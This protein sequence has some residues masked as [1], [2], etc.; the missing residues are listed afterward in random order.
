MVT[1]M[2]D[3]I[4]L[5]QKKNNCHLEPNLRLLETDFLRIRYQHSKIPINPSNML[6]AVVILT[7]C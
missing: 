6:C 5:K 1:K 2:A 7:F 3:K 4:G